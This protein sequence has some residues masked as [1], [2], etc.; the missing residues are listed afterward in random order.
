MFAAVG[1][2]AGIA[3]SVAA[4]DARTLQTSLQEWVKVQKQI[5]DDRTAWRA[6]KEILGDSIAVLERQRTTLQEAIALSQQT[7]TA[8]DDERVALAGERE[9]LRELAA[10]AEA[11]VAAQEAAIL[12]LN[13]RLPP[14][15]QEE[16][17]PLR[18]RIPRDGAG[19]APL[20]A[21]LQ[22][23]VG[24][25]TQIDKFNSGVTLVSELREIGG[26]AREVRTLYFGLAG[27]YF[28]D[29]SGAYGG[30][31]VPGAQGWEWREEP[32]LT[33]PLADLFAVYANTKQAQFVSLPV[34]IR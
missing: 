12:A 26:G 16:I 11:R 17:A 20:G 13:E 29:A 1:C 30:V 25:L 21:R 3:A 15:L 33:G 28:L 34:Q 6:E 14:P 32:G 5:A 31:G 4:Q 24:I 7:A 27:A 19:N 22:N 10:I 2:A 9:R 8:A 18:R 23:I